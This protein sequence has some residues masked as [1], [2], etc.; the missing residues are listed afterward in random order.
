MKRVLPALLA[1]TLLAACGD[2][3][4]GDEVSAT[5]T[6]ESTT[7]TSTT[8]LA[9]NP[10]PEP[11][12]DGIRFT[13]DVPDRIETSAAV[14]V[15]EVENRSRESV[16]LTFPTGQRGDVELERSDEVAHRWSDGRFF[17]QAVEEIAVEPGDTVT[18]ELADDLSSVEPGF[19]TLRASLAVVGAPEPVERS[20]RVREAR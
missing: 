2:D 16:T 17:T 13:V 10:P 3:D 18:F 1:L 4:G 8:A 12:G 9:D 19:Y 14:W 15:L 7:T 20:V 6:T 11:A 5:T